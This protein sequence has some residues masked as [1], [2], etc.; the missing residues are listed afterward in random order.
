MI[1]VA[2]VFAAISAF[3]AF[4]L[5]ELGGTRRDLKNQLS[6]A[7]QKNK[8]LQSRL[9][10]RREKLSKKA[11][12][13]SKKDSKVKGQLKR[14]EQQQTELTAARKELKEAQGQVKEMSRELNRV[15]IEREQLRGEIARRK[16]AQAEADAEVAAMTSDTGDAERPVAEETVTLETP[17][18]VE[19]RQLKSD[20]AKAR[21]QVERLRSQV[22]SLKRSVVERES[23]LRR[24]SQ[25]SESNRRAYIITQLQLDLLSDENYV[26]KHGTQPPYPQAAKREKQAQLRG[27]QPPESVEVLHGATIDLIGVGD[28]AGEDI[29]EAFLEE[30]TTEEQAPESVEET[31]VAAA[32]E[33]VAPEPVLAAPLESDAAPAEEVT[34]AAPAEEVEETGK[35]TTRLRRRTPTQEELVIPPRP[36]A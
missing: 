25:K 24:L 6:A 31:E 26:L 10:G 36:E 7:E 35:K 34:E 18:R 20:L 15:R 5:A 14:I 12:E 32:E 9:E 33:E 13:A 4:R 19:V 23:K 11:Q 16:A 8:K 27:E 28:R 1:V 2:V 30:E 22:S 21:D 3:L 29:E 17:V